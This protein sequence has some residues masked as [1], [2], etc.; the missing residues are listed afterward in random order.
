MASALKAL[1]S[2]LSLSIKMSIVPKSNPYSG[3]YLTTGVNYVYILWRIEE[4]PFI[5]LIYTVEFTS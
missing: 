3:E 4:F 5:I 1:S 2:I